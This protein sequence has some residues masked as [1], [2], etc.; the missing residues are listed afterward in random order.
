MEPCDPSIIKL[1]DETGESLHSIVKQ[2]SE[3]WEALPIF[4]IPQ[5]AFAKAIVFIIHPLLK[6]HNVGLEPLDFLP[7]DIVLDPDSGSESGDNGPELVQGQIRCGSEDILHRGGR[8]GEPPG[9]GG[10]KSNSCT[11]LSDHA[12]SKGIVRAEA[13]MSWEV[14]SGLFRG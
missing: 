14:V 3:V 12:H 6:S 11:L 5:W 7:M 2:D 13:K 1:L 9:V 10:G 4:F 8:E